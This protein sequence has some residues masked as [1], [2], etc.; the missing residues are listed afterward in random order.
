MRIKITIFFVAL[1]ACSSFA[2]ES[3]PLETFKIDPVKSSATWS[4][5][6]I[7]GEHSGVIALDSGFLKLRG[8]ALEQGSVTVDMKSLKNIDLTKLEDRSK[9][10]KHLQSKDFFATEDHPQSFFKIKEV[11]DMGNGQF[12]V[13]GDM[14]IRGETQEEKF[15]TKV[16]RAGNKL[17]AVADIAIDRTKYGIMYKASRTDGNEWFFS[18]WF[19][20]GKDKLI[21]NTLD[22]KLNIVA[23]KKP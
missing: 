10:E 23:D 11:K 6:K 9:L 1:M 3:A 20:G 18:R 12:S 13:R 15:V 8:N 22:I 5:S 4:G 19:K 21:N 16:N 2:Y 14:T 17:V 7:G